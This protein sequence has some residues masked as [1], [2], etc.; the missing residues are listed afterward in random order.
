MEAAAPIREAEMFRRAFESEWKE[1]PRDER[2]EI[3]RLVVAGHAPPPGREDLAAWLAAELYRSVPWTWL[4]VPG[5]VVFAGLAVLG[6]WDAST[7]TATFFFAAWA[8]AALARVIAQRD[9]LRRDA[10]ERL[11]TAWRLSRPAR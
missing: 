7:W 5:F 10:R 3:R 9:L 1:V 8:F 2:R 4:A 6:L 11:A